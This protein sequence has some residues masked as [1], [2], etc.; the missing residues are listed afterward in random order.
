MNNPS[1]IN[2]QKHPIINNQITTTTT[3]TTK[4][5]PKNMPPQK[6]S[7]ITVTIELRELYGIYIYQ[8]FGGVPVLLLK[9]YYNLNHCICCTTYME[10]KKKVK[11]RIATCCASCGKYFSGEIDLVKNRCRSCNKQNSPQF[12]LKRSDEQTNVGF[13]LSDTYKSI[14]TGIGKKIQ[15]NCPFNTHY[16]IL[17]RPK[18]N[19]IITINKINGSPSFITITPYIVHDPILITNVCQACNK[20]LINGG[21]N[22]CDK[23]TAKKRICL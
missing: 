18:H 16:V 14:T 17:K 21:T 6:K 1:L 15:L 3:T 19:D 4:R 7:Q 23:C 5:K 2:D 11:K 10:N 9:I 13:K 12:I 8:K 20:T 22:I